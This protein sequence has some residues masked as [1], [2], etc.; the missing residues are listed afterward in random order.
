MTSHVSFLQD[1]MHDKNIIRALERQQEEEEEE[2]IR[3]F[4]KA[5]KRLIQMR[6]DKEAETNRLGFKNTFFLDFF[7]L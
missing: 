2:K 5:K 7:T 1:H 4:I 3:R 6:Q